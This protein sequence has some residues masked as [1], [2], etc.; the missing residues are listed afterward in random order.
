MSKLLKAPIPINDEER[1]KTLREYEVL[2]TLQEKQLDEITEAVALICNCKIALISLIDKDR[3]WFKSKHGIDADETPR[4]VSYCGHAIT[5]DDLFIVEDAELDERFCDNPLYL[6]E[7]HVKFYAGA[8][9]IAPNGHRIGTLCVIDSETK[10]LDDKQKQILK[11][12]AKQVITFLEARRLTRQQF[13]NKLELESYKRGLDSH[14]IIARTDTRGKITFVNDKFCDIS[15]FSRDELIGKDHRIISSGFHS[16]E[17]FKEMWTSI[18]SGSIW[19]A[20]ICNKAK[21]GSLYWVDTIITPLMD[22]KGNIHEFMA[23]RYDITSRKQNEFLFSE[24]QKTAHIGSWELDVKTYETKWTDEI[25]RIHEVEIGSPV[26]VA[27]GINFYAVHERERISNY[28][29]NC[30]EKGTP[31]ESVFEFITAKNNKKWV[32]SQGIPVKNNEG[33]IIKVIGTFQDVTEFKLKE[34]QVRQKENKFRQLFTQSQDAVMTLEP[35]TWGFKSCNPA[36]LKLFKVKNEEEYLKLGPWSISPE[37]QPDG[38]LSSEKAK[39]MIGLALEKGFHSFYWVHTTICGEEIPCTVLLSRI[40]E[41]DKVYLHA[42]IR[43]ISEQKM[44]EDSLRVSNRELEQSLNELNATKQKLSL[45]YQ[46]SPFGFAFCDMQ[47]VLIDVN[48]KYEEITGYCLDELKNLSYWDI[49]PK[50]YEEEEAKQIKHLK[51]TGSYGPYRKEYQNKDGRLIPV[52]LNGFVI[53]DFDGKE[54]IWSIAEDLTEKI[55]QERELFEQKKIATHHAKL[56]SIG[57][58]AAGVGHEIN[59]PLAI[60]KGYLF[61]I[62]K[63]VEAGDLETQDLQN[64]I[65]KINLATERIAKIVQGLRTFARSD[66][67]EINEFSPVK[68]LQESVYMLSEIYQKEGIYLTLNQNVLEKYVINGNAGKFQQV[69]MNLISNAKDAT[70]GKEVR[71]IDISMTSQNESLIIKVKDNG[72]GIPHS[73]EEKIFEPFFT[74]KEVNKG[75][76]IGLSLVH[77]FIKEM[78]GTCHVQSEQDKGTTF[79][80]E[81]PIKKADIKFMPLDLSPTTPRVSSR[82]QPKVYYNA[83][84]ILADDEEGI[85]ELLSEI[86][87]EM[88]INVTVVQ[89]GK[90]AYELYIK[91]PEKY[92]LIISDMQMPEMDGPTLLQA[93]RSTPNLDQPKFIFITGGTNVSFEDDKNHLNNFIDGYFYKPFSE[94][95][96]LEVLD[97]CLSEKIK[98]AS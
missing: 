54:G 44:L 13:K 96:I 25:Y 21:D 88:G 79:T 60:V 70:E 18:S 40:S 63:K 64:Y 77:N 59:N 9:L 24:T 47:G 92:D 91:S 14:A 33:D 53:K 75:T 31:F 43:D 58:L 89:N 20:E 62:E 35:P 34:I 86:L 8:P 66:S 93:L 72:C 15:Q 94:Q 22:N 50:K 3:Q 17:F 2:D 73:L 87:G 37:M 49:T 32:H 84:V 61:T 38:D 29:K 4:D 42:I 30:I 27:D 46:N 16:K 39:R 1:L 51:T 74:T 55:N 80:L 85:R 41:E 95:E 65:G 67:S 5:G 56:A 19:R 76:G 83:N 81:L 11:V 52:E 36:T 6:N 26:N 48:K 68:A 69:L 10:T 57:E 97:K 90:E 12:L 78:D 7:P 98:K 23:F 71:N 45:F 28:V 82:A